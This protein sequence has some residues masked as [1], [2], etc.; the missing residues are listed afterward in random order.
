MSI[1]FPCQQSA[2]KGI[3]QRRKARLER[4]DEGP[5]GGGRSLISESVL[6]AHPVWMRVLRGLDSALI[7]LHIITGPDVPR[8]RLLAME[9]LVEAI[10]AITHFHFNQLI[11]VICTPANGEG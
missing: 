5:D 2:F 6:W 1:A 9:E 10:T 7:A 3:L 4:R 11:T 8:G